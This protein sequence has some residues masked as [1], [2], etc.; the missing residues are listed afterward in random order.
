M[1]YSLITIQPSI[2]LVI[3]VSISMHPIHESIESKPLLSFRISCDRGAHD[4]LARERCDRA[5]S[6]LIAPL[7]Y[8]CFAVLA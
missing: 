1:P 7:G 6:E 3:Y 8:N 5:I 2:Y 4:I